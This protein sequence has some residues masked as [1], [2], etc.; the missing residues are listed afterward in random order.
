MIITKRGAIVGA[1]VLTGVAL[2]ASWKHEPAPAKAVTAGAYAPII[3][4][5]D[6]VLAFYRRIEAEEHEQIAHLPELTGANKIVVPDTD[7]AYMLAAAMDDFGLVLSCS[8]EGSARAVSLSFRQEFMPWDDAAIKVQALRFKRT[9]WGLIAGI[10]DGNEAWSRALASVADGKH[11]SEAERAFW[12]YAET[13]DADSIDLTARFDP[14]ADDAAPT[15][16]TPAPSTCVKNLAG[17]CVS[18]ATNGGV[19]P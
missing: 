4:P 9:F 19:Q 7:G 3:T 16:A 6:K 2:A 1:V 12:T 13:K 10:A 8:R 15:E 5:C 11:K 18:A 14:L 17:E